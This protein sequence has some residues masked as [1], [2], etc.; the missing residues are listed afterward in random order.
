MRSKAKTV[1]FGIIYGISAFGLSQ[2]INISRTEAKDIIEAYFEK[3]PKIKQYMDTN[4][5]FAREHGYVET[6]MKRRRYL[7]DINSANAVMRGYAERNAINA[8]IQG[9]AADIIKVAMI[10]IQRELE[11]QHFQSKMLL[12]VHDEL[13]FDAK[14]DELEKL[15][16][17]VQYQMENAV[18][19]SVPL[20]VEVGVGENWLEAH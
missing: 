10:N 8:P 14:K 11:Q 13:L 12:Q 1:N 2:R 17:V 4:I 9:S 3:Y 6:I 15:K 7:N 18:K 16:S 19:L 20:T 5:N